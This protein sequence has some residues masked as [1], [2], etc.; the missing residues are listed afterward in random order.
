M[1][2]ERIKKIRLIYTVEYYSDI[3]KKEMMPFAAIRMDLEI[4]VLSKVSQKEK[5]KYHMTSRTCG[6]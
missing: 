4:M 1:T 6:L 3:K 5:D 2:D